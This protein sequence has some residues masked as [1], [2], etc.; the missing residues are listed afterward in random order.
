MDAA[1]GLSPDTS[2]VGGGVT[3]DED[4]R[5]GDLFASEAPSVILSD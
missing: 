5:R 4:E 2:L 1:A 3:S